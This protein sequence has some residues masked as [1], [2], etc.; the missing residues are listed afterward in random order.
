VS[1][2]H[3]FGL[4]F[5]S[6]FVADSL[7]IWRSNVT[8][9]DAP[10]G[11]YFIVLDLDADQTL[12]STHFDSLTRRATSVTVCPFGP[13]IGVSVIRSGPAPTFISAPPSSQP[14]S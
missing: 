3:T 14:L 2:V 7:Q 10:A 8:I 11:N 13:D 5:P 4:Q 1:T 6:V 12:A 9:A